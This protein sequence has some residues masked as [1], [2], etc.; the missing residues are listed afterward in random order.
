M[1]FGIAGN[2][3]EALSLLMLADALPD[4]IVMDVNMPG[5]NGIECLARLKVNS[6]LRNIPVVMLSSA[7][8]ETALVQM[9]G[10]MGFIQ[11]SGNTTLFRE[12]LNETLEKIISPQATAKSS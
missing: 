1:L 11:K 4:F 7:V 3:T 9:I 5:M 12:Q 2:G 6:H 8:W 10:A